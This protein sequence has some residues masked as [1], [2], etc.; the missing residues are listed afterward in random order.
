MARRYDSKDSK[1]RILSAC[2]KFFI[3]NGYKNTKMADIIRE[4]DV[5]ASTFQNIFR[6]KD[7]VLMELVEFMFEN[8]FDMANQMVAKLPSPAYLYAMETSIQLV[9]A[10]IN[11]NMRDVYVEAYTFPQTADYIHEHTSSVLYKIFGSYMPEYSESD[12]YELEIGSSGIMRAY[13]ARP[14]DKYFTL[15]KK[16][17]RFLTMSLC[18]YKVPEEEQKQIIDYILKIDIRQIAYEVMQHLFTALAMKF[19]FKLTV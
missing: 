11:E 13:M 10:E 12:F 17:E 19:D 6:T 5:S 7:G 8:Q 18:V 14:C 1:R 9:L 4:A 15:E 3:E 2:V 16:L